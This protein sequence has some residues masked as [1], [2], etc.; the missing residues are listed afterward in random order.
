LLNNSSLIELYISQNE[1]DMNSDYLEKL[2]E[3]GVNIYI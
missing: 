3:K 2:R 1:I